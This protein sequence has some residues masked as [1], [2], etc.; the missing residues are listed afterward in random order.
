MIESDSL[1]SA[2]NSTEPVV[3][4]EAVRRPLA[5]V[6]V[7]TLAEQYP[8]PFA[9]MVMSDLGA[10]VIAIERP[11][12]GDP[13]R[14]FPGLFDALNRGKRSV[15]LDLKTR[16][17]VAACRKLLQSADVILEGYRPGVLKRLGIDLAGGSGEFERAIRVSISG[18]GQT[19]PYRL[20][21]G[22]DL[23]FQ[24][25]VGT[26]GSPQSPQMPELSLADLSSA[27]FA[28]VASLCG[29]VSRDATG[30]GGYY[31][32]AMFDSLVALMTISIVPQA[33][34]EPA[35]RLG[36]DPGYGIYETSDG[37]RIALSI[38]FEDHFWR[39]LCQCVGLDAFAALTSHERNQRR[40]ELS[41]ALSKALGQRSLQHWEQTLHD[42]AIPFGAVNGT[43][44]LLLDPHFLVRNL[45]QSVESRGGVRNYLR[46]PLLV[47]GE[48]LGPTAR[49]PELGEHTRAVLATLGLAEG[50]VDVC[51]AD[52]LAHS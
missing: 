32:V 43:A 27:M 8:G 1:S 3:A 25:M 45:V 15:A 29:L 51:V 30:E 17:G 33:N 26:L 42:A 11:Q 35:E 16:H 13:S 34:E 20:R 5:G 38:A 9:G 37:R 18:F 49:A 28:I 44:E 21:P 39:A 46:Q 31:D 47:D 41:A 22:H 12:G 52:V 4:R 24:A 19:G 40:D 2:V 48:P 36:L 10:D 6:R 23:S 50:L 14:Q 7:V